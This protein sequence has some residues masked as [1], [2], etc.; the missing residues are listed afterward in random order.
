MRRDAGDEA[1]RDIW[2]DEDLIDSIDPSRSPTLPAEPMVM[3]PVE[4]EFPKLCSC[5]WPHTRAEWIQLKPRTWRMAD[6]QM[7]EAAE[8]H[9]LS[10]MTVA[11]EEVP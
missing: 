11:L 7:R 9:C 1:W 6:G 5:G 10:T 8:C 2:R 3:A 4:S